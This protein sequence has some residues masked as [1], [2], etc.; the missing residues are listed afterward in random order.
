M[1]RKSNISEL[2][3][4]AVNTVLPCS[5]DLAIEQEYPYSVYELTEN[6]I[7]DKKEICGWEGKGYIYIVDDNTVRLD[8]NRDSIVEALENLCSSTI[9]FEIVDQELGSDDSTVWAYRIEYKITKA[10]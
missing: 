1:S 2:I 6:P 5:L 8:Q 10:L 7:Y 9:K 4:G 3:V